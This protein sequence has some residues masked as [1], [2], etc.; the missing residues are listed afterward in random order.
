[1][2]IRW[3][4]A[5]FLVGGALADCP[6][7]EFIQPSCSCK[8][9]FVGTHVVCSNVNS[10]DT[11]RDVFNILVNYRVATLL[12]R[13]LRTAD[14]LPS[15][16]FRGMN[17]NNLHLVDSVFSFRDRDLPFSGLEASLTQLDLMNCNVGGGGLART[18][19]THLLHLSEFNV[20]FVH[21]E[22]VSGDWFGRGP[23]KIKNLRLDHD[24]ITS[25]EEG[26]F[27]G[28]TQ[29]QKLSLAD[30]RLQDVNRGILPRPAS[31]LKWLDLSYNRLNSLPE[32][33]FHDMPHLKRVVLS[34][35]RFESLPQNTWK[36]V[37]TMLDHLLLK[38]NP[39]VCDGNIKWLYED[40]RRD[41]LEGTCN[42]P[43]ELQGTELSGLTAD[44]L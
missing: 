26:A 5:L 27:R 9:L 4:L 10:T 16:V 31:K 36:V 28:L 41:R 39:V 18:N 11:L 38:D 33:F 21:L 35:N 42:S 2:L 8:T 17:V 15:D 14:P 13:G 29:L 37:W 12:F 7:S 30:N 1:M 6:N 24:E 25:V 43:E 23:D 40:P 34:G 44:Q 22:T 32:D 19:L 20:Q 3:T